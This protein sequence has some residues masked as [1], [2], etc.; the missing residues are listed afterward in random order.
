MTQVEEVSSDETSVIFKTSC[1][2]YDNDHDLTFFLEYEDDIKMLSIL[3]N[4]VGPAP[5]CFYS[6]KPWYVKAYNRIKLAIKVLTTGRITYQE[7]F[8]FR[9]DKQIN[10]LVS[11]LLQGSTLLK[12][13]KDDDIL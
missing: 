2:C 6:D 7:S 11:A 13:R 3:Y 12:N 9:G 1:S 10:D 4:V 8:I 5:Y